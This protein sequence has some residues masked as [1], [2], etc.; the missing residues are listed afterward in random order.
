MP[1]IMVSWHTHY[2][3]SYDMPEV[4][5]KTGLGLTDIIIARGEFKP[6]LHPELFGGIIIYISTVWLEWN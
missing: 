1:S 5:N 4:F 2:S 6:V 3:L